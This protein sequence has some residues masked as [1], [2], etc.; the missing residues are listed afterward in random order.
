[1]IGLQPPRHYLEAVSKGEIQLPNKTVVTG[2]QAPFSIPVARFTQ[3]RMVFEKPSLRVHSQFFATRLDSEILQVRPMGTTNYHP[4]R[5]R[6]WAMSAKIEH[7]WAPIFSDFRKFYQSSGSRMKLVMSKIPGRASA[8][9]HSSLGF[10][11][12]DG[13]QWI[14]TAWGITSPILQEEAHRLLLGIPI[15]HQTVRD[16][17]IEGSPRP[18]RTATKIT[19]FLKANTPVPGLPSETPVH[20]PQVSRASSPCRP[21]DKPTSVHLEEYRRVSQAYAQC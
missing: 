14:S 5:G 15:P 6:S 2:L 19:Q 21:L 8:N 4:A 3:T 7:C 20:P 11:S 9:G 1:M 16:L 10:Q 12:A 13:L 18:H 17:A